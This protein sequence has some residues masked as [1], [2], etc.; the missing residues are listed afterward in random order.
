M[1]EKLF[2]DTAVL[3]KQVYEFLQKNKEVVDVLHGNEL[4]AYSEV[5]DYCDAIYVLE[6]YGESNEDE[7]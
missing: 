5:V 3:L 7:E 2:Q 4:L 6:T 1:N